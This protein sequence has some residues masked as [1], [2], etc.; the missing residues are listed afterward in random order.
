MKK[1]ILI[2]LLLFVTK[3]HG[4]DNI[5]LSGR[6]VLGTQ[7]FENAEVII[8]NINDKAI[9]KVFTDKDGYYNIGLR[10]GIYF[11]EARGDI[12]G[13]KYIGFSGKNPLYLKEDTYAGIKLLLPSKFSQRKLK[14]KDII[15]TVKSNHNN[16]PVAG[17][18]A[19]LYLNEKDIKGMPFFYSEPADKKGLIK[20]SNLI[21]GI[22]YIVIRK[23]TDD[24]PLGPL[25][26]GDLIGFYDKNPVMLKEGYKYNIEIPLFEKVQDDITKPVD[27]KKTFIIKGTAI[28]EKGEF[29]SGVYA[30]LYTKKEMG[31]ERPISISK[32][33]KEDGRFEL[34]VPYAGKY[35]LG[36]RQ[37]YG[38]TPVQGELYGLYD[39]TYDHHIK[40][41]DN[42][43]GITIRIKKILR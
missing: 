43:T 13:K 36:V 22:Y 29:V 1:L 7:G 24:S 25:S 26:E 30:F 23:K 31:H 6:V 2:L 34:I 15:L 11:I 42:I 4:E 17:A 16:Q 38:G 32:K 3:L 12:K 35:Y 10:E 18:R 14:N 19:Y 27:A 21:E 8:R 39:A 33:T 28:N 9:Y 41:F 37:F 20:I 5:N 40:V